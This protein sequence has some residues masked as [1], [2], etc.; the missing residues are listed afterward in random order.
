MDVVAANARGNAA[1]EV[2][3]SQEVVQ[4]DG[5][6]WHRN[7]MIV[8]GQAAVDIPQQKVLRASGNNVLL[9]CQAEP[10]YSEELAKDILE[11][12]EARLEAIQ[13]QPGRL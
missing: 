6:V 11:G 3:G 10:L 7:W 9:R 12:F 8:A 5:D 4:V 2:F 1:A 13:N